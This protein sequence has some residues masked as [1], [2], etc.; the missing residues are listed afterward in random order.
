MRTSRQELLQ[1]ERQAELDSTMRIF[2]QLEKIWASD[3]TQALTKELAL[4][5][6]KARLEELGVLLKTSCRENFPEKED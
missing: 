3:S 1:M 6:R 5:T 2:A 4:R